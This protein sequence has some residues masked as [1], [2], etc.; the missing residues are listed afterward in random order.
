[1]RRLAVFGTSAKIVMD[2][3]QNVVHHHSLT[4]GEYAIAT[5]YRG[6][7]N[8]LAREF[9][10]RV[11]ALVKE[12]GYKNCSFA[13]RGLYDNG[14][15]GAW[16]PVIHI[17]EPRGDRDPSSKAA[18]QM[19]LALVLLRAGRAGRPVSARR[20]LHRVPGAV[21]ALGGVGRRHVRQLAGH[22]GARRRQAAAAGTAAQGP[23]HRLPDQ[24][25]A[26]GAD[27]DEEFRGRDAARRHQLL[28]RHH[29]RRGHPQRVRGQPRSE[30]SARRQSAT[31]ASASRARS[32]RICS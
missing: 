6:N 25:A 27:L 30:P 14:A 19:A 22:G 24:A 18:N 9:E 15:L 31:C 32:T 4:A 12:F 16:V 8:T 1:M 3:F 13:V 23:G 26:A 17:I 21:L 28:R 5:D 11:A 20:R 10:V 29:A 2:D 7:V